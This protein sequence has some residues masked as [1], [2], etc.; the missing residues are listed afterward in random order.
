MATV[1]F[2]RLAGP[3]GF[4]RI[5]AVKR[6]APRLA[7]DPGF[8]AMFV[9][10][11][12]VASRVVH[13]NVVP[14]LDVVVEGGE[15]F[16]VMEYVRGQSLAALLGASL[17]AG[18][19]VPV[20]VAAAIMAGAL[21]GLH[22][23]HEARDKR[24]QP[25]GIVHRDVS[26]QN[27]LVGADGIAR[28]MDFGVAKAE[29]KLHVAPEGQL[30]G[31]L[32]YM[33]PEQVRGDAVDRR[34]DVFAAAVV[35]WGMLAGRR[36]FRGEDASVMNDVLY[37]EIP[38]LS[39]HRDDVPAAVEAALA[40]ALERD[41]A[42][43]TP[44]AR[45][46]ALALEAATPL[47]SPSV[48]G[49]WVESLAGPVLA[50]REALIAQ[51]ENTASAPTAA[52]LA[53]VAA[54]A[55]RAKQDALP[56][57]PETTPDRPRD[58]VAPTRTWSPSTLEATPTAVAGASGAFAAPAAIPPAGPPVPT[59]PAR[60]SPALMM[61]ATASFAA[62][63]LGAAVVVLVRARAPFPEPPGLAASVVTMGPQPASSESAREAPTPPA[64]TSSVAVA[65]ASAEKAPAAKPPP[66]AKGARRPR[67]KGPAPKPGDDL[68][69]I[70]SA[71]Q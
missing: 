49:A 2:G 64:A 28:V 55:A 62:I 21:S 56:A 50:E 70:P 53:E 11:A 63:A 58:S 68:G 24:G 35:L 66:A 40:R 32:S 33:A 30:V 12:T 44:T 10:E 38:P 19:R 4:S 51:I 22:A 34:A 16:I 18:A 65:S 71:N 60:L 59:A 48:V 26:P 47:A 69:Y 45:D 31:K 20:P 14:T 1:Y 43:R 54:S 17:R 5:V 36:L 52:A 41:P 7:R 13:P 37:G 15:I 39:R 29:S 9:D 57:E 61:A 27:V 8:V 25:L 23:A 3:I 46:F 67:S 6:M 42:R